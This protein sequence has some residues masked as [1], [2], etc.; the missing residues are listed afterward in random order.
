[1]VSSL[2]LRLQSG[3]RRRGR[4]T[5]DGHNGS[6]ALASPATAAGAND[7]DR[8]LTAWGK[9]HALAPLWIDAHDYQGKCLYRRQ[10]DTR[11]FLARPGAATAVD[12]NDVP[13]EEARPEGEA[14]RG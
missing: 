2:E 3:S 1:M 8:S 14:I 4:S 5:L 10:G 7:R 12:C 11:L 13:T 9:P 6:E